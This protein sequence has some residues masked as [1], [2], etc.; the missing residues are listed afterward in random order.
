[1]NLEFDAPTAEEFPLV[2]DAWAESFR[3]S[4]WAGCIPNRLYDE[5][6]RTAIAELIDRGA[7]VRVAV[8]PLPD[9]GRRVLGYSVTEPGHRVLH[10]LYVKQPYRGVGV[11][12]RILEECCPDGKWAYTYRT[13]ASQKFLGPRFA[14]EPAQARVKR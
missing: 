6:A 13:K 7:R 14:H 3:K 12:R 8:I 10:W 2:F 1:M 11:G 5:V 4:P 9:G